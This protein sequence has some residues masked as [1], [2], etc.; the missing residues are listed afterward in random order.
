MSEQKEVSNSLQNPAAQRAAGFCS[1]QALQNPFIHRDYRGMCNKPGSRL[2][3][4]C[5][6][7]IVEIRSI[8]ETFPPHG[9]PN[10][11]PDESSAPPRIPPRAP[12]ISPVAQPQEKFKK[13]SNRHHYVSRNHAF[14]AMCYLWP[15]LL[16]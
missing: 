15:K 8:S 12:A 6:I 2:L 4:I 13:T 1:I 16:P 10:E 5:S 3:P 11:K 7:A 9:G 14:G